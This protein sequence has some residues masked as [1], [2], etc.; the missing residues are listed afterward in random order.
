VA[1]VVGAFAAWFHD[2]VLMIWL[3]VIIPFATWA[4][5]RITG[6]EGFVDLTNAVRREFTQKR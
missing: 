5:L 4:L 1:T 3:G 6:L 2:P